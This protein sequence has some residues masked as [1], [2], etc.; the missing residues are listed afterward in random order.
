MKPTLHER[1]HLNAIWRLSKEFLP[2]RWQVGGVLFLGFVIAAVQPLCIKLSQTIIDELQK[3]NNEAFFR[4]IPLALIGIFLVS[5]LAK[6]F[7]TAFRRYI[8]EKVII[9]MRTDLFHKYLMFP[10]A[11][12][13]EKR[14]GDM[15]STIQN[16]LAQIN[17]GVETLCDIL[18]EPFIFLGLVGVALYWD[19]Q[20]TLV[21]LITAPLV[22]MLFAKSGSAVKRYS[23]KNLNQFSDLVSLGQESIAGARVVKVF[24]LESTLL[25]KFRKVQDDYLKTIWK[26]IKVQE[27]ATPGVEFI[28][29]CLM[30]GIILYGK[31]RISNGW[32]TTG[33][34]IAFIVALGLLQMP[35][36]KLNLAYLKMKNAEAAAERIYKVLDTPDVPARAFAGIRKADF[37]REIVFD[38]VGVFYGEK[39]A[40]GNVSFRVRH[41]EKIAFVGPSGGGKSSIVNLIPRLYEISEG[42]ITID[43]VDISHIHLSDLRGLISFVTQDIF[44]FNDSIFENIRYGNLHAS[45]EQVL[46]AAELAHCLDFIAKCPEGIHSSIGDRG[47]CL[48]GGE[49]QRIAIA[50]AILKHAPILVLDE[51]TSSLDSHSEAIVQSALDTLMEGKTTFMVAHRFSTVRRADRIFVLEAGRIQESGRHEELMRS[52]GLYSQ[53]YERQAL[54]GEPAFT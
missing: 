18:K 11:V 30:G 43:G 40:L 7:H 4:W 16:D 37:E 22:V 17:S 29:A 5:G 26:S 10:L 39:R 32:L 3:S 42:Q 1:L 36:K 35:I 23:A 19:W 8:S 21:T 25:D 47:V 9:K 52:R 44:L 31:Y 38:K 12:T 33:Q 50:R 6:Y 41:G 28:G 48:S 13:D 2:Y 45:T 27:V 24:R 53:L 14:T 34:L 54:M 15:L 20:L 49:R 46:K 51:A